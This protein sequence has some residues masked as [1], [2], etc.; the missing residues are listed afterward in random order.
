MPQEMTD[1]E[2]RKRCRPDQWELIRAAA[3]FDGKSVG[4]FAL[5]AAL[6]LARQA[7]MEKWAFDKAA[8]EVKVKGEQHLQAS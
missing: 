1:C 6:Q 8:E 7:L 3:E 5:N 4:T 2:I